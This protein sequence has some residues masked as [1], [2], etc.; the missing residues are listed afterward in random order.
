VHGDPHS[1][2]AQAFLEIAAGLRERVE[3]GIGH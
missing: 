3:H 1:S 2:Q